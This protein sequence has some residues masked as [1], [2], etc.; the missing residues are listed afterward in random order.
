MSISILITEGNRILIGA[1]NI[2]GT[3]ATNQELLRRMETK[4]KKVYKE[5]TLRKDIEELT[6][7]YKNNGYLKIEIDEPVI[8]FDEARTKCYRAENKR[9]AEV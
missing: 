4:K 2:E 8:T 5:E 6:L 1:V 3:K 7:F 9:R